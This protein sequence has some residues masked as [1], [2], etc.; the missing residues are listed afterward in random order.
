MTEPRDG[1]LEA[2]GPEQQTRH[3]EARIGMFGVVRG[4]T[5]KFRQGLAKFLLREK[6]D[7]G[8]MRESAVSGLGSGRWHA[9]RPETCRETMFEPA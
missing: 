5:E 9:A 6:P 2:Q 3:L 4:D 7:S 8:F 1:V